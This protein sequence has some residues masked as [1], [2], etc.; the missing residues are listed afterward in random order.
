M[1]HGM[2]EAGLPEKPAEAGFALLGLQVYLGLKP[3]ATRAPSVL[4]HAELELRV[5]QMTQAR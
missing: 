1:R 2:A 5:S 3:Q 4:K